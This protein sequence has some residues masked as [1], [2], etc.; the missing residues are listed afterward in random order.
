M[1]PAS[2]IEDL[3]LVPST[4]FV[5]LKIAVFRKEGEGEGGKESGKERGRER[6][7]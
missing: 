7:Q 1:A 4:P 5:Y 6:K 2:P 3:D